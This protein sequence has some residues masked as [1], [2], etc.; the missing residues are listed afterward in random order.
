MEFKEIDLAEFQAGNKDGGRFQVHLLPEEY[1]GVHSETVPEYLPYIQEIGRDKFIAY[2]RFQA[3]E[4]DRDA[5]HIILAV[6]QY[7]ISKF[8][9]GLI[10]GPG[11]AGIHSGDIQWQKLKNLPVSVA[12]FVFRTKTLIQLNGE[13]I[14]VKQE[15]VDWQVY[16]L[17]PPAAPT[18]AERLAETC[19]LELRLIEE[20]LARLERY[21]L[22]ERNAGEVRILTY[23]ES[24]IR[25]Q[26]IYE[27]DLPFTLENGVIKARKK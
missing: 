22:V 6:V 10:G 3:R 24:L 25:N 4:T 16:H 17:I 26:M 9:K 18:T 15:D 14:Q 23:G 19:G 2:R 7:L 8:D 21:C 12:R 13:C 11:R 1:A 27:K 20:S 5:L